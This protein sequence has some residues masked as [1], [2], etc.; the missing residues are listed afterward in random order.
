MKQM[1]AIAG[2]AFA[3]ANLSPAFAASLYSRNPSCER[4]LEARTN[5]ICKTLEREMEWTWTGHAI[6]APSFRVTF[7]TARRTYCALPI[8]ANDAATLVEMVLA[9]ERKPDR[10]MSSAQIGNGGR[11]LL[12]LLGRR[13]LDAFPARD[14]S[15]DEQSRQI[16]KNLREEIALAIADPAMIWNPANPQYLLREGCR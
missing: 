12:N 16:A 4:W 15:W 3:L 10:T 5:E 1:L 14:K 2:F 9:L 11:F 7:E 6:L 8:A 13:A